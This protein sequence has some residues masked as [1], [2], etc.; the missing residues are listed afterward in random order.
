MRAALITC[1]LVVAVVASVLA[2]PFPESDKEIEA[3][4]KERKQEDQE[5]HPFKRA[6]DTEY[7]RLDGVIEAMRENEK[8]EDGNPLNKR[9]Q[10]DMEY[11][12][13]S[14]CSVGDRVDVS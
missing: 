10:E 14:T 2:L 4:K 11:K 8:E 9:G 6:Q 13:S 3:L 5:S 12:R 7:K 1:V